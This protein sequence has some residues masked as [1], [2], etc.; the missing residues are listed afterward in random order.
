MNSIDNIFEKEVIKESKFNDKKFS[1]TTTLEDQVMNYNVE[2][3]SIMKINKIDFHNE[4]SFMLGIKKQISN[5]QL[6]P[7]VVCFLCDKKYINKFKDDNLSPLVKGDIA[8]YVMLKI[9]VDMFFEK[10]KYVQKREGLKKN[11]ELESAKPA[12]NLDAFVAATYENCNGIYIS[13]DHD[14]NKMFYSNDERYIRG[15]INDNLKFKTIDYKVYIKKLAESKEEASQY[16]TDVTKKL[17]RFNEDE[18]IKEMEHV[19][20]F[21]NMLEKILNEEVNKEFETII[22]NFLKN[23]IV[24]SK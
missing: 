10:L 8:A 7:L 4:A 6:L 5:R 12:Y 17:L 16:L 3:H 11:Y 19:N 23:T 24:I 13:R 20:E 2:L 9:N 1:E 14:S 15:F 21:Y 22:S 18:F